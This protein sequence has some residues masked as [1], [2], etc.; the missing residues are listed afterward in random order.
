MARAHRGQIG[1]RSVSSQRDHGNI[2]FTPAS[3][4]RM[5]LAKLSE[6]AAAE[7]KE[8]LRCEH[9]SQ[10][11]PLSIAAPNASYKRIPTATAAA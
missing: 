1:L 4:R 5:I 2:P 11:R 8:V 9:Q 10:D 7:K 6:Q 3:D